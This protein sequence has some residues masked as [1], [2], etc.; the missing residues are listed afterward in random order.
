[1]PNSSEWEVG[2]EGD[3]PIHKAVV[4]GKSAF[5]RLS[6]GSSH[7]NFLVIPTR[8]KILSATSHGISAWTKTAK[9]SAIL[10]NGSLTTYFMKVNVTSSSTL[11]LLMEA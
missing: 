1:M 9:I 6:L 7:A 4:G 5:N 8:T 11:R 10:S 2:L 3:F